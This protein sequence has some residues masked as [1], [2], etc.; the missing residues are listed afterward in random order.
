MQELWSLGKALRADCNE[1][2]HTMANVVNEEETIQLNRKIR[3]LCNRLD[4][5]VAQEDGYLV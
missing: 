4:Q 3:Y 5:Y 1:K 2:M